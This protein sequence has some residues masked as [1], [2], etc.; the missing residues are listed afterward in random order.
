MAFKQK[1]TEDNNKVSLS[2]EVLFELASRSE[3]VCDQIFNA[4]E[5]IDNEFKGKKLLGH[6]VVDDAGKPLYISGT[7]FCKKP[8][9]YDLLELDYIESDDYLD[10]MNDKSLII[11]NKKNERVIT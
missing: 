6:R 5:T 9:E 3:K 8:G 7:F 4:L 11:M 1:Y 10:L 2:V